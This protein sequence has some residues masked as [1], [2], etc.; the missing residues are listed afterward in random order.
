MGWVGLGWGEGLGFAELVGKLLRV[1]LGLEP[2]DGFQSGFVG[3]LIANH[4]RLMAKGDEGG[5]KDAVGDGVV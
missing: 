4:G 3:R 5:F 2:F 1:R